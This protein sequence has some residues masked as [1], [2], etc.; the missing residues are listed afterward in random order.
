MADFR[1]APFRDLVTRLHREPLVQNAL[2]G[3]PQRH[4]RRSDPDEPDTG[5][6]FGDERVGAPCGPAAGP[7]TQLAQ[8]IL[9]SYVAGGRVIELKTAHDQGRGRVPNAAASFLEPDVWIDWALP[10]SLADAA[11]EY[12]AG[13]M[14]IEMFRR[15]HGL[16]GG[17]NEG[18]SGSWAFEV[19]VGYD[20]AGISRAGVRGF[21]DE[22]AQAGAVV[23]RLRSEIP[24]EFPEAREHAY[25]TR[26]A[27]A[28]SLS[29]CRD[30]S[31]DEIEK[32][33][34]LLIGQ[35]GLDLSLRLDAG[36]SGRKSSKLCFAANWDT[37]T[38]AS[39]RR[40]LKPACRCAR[41][42]RS[43]GGLEPAPCDAAGIFASNSAGRSKFCARAGS[44]PG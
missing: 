11:C 22:I 25:P 36:C 29:V 1:P 33:G 19:G 10:V 18:L 17:G 4:W 38:C 39:T 8:G 21:L 7:H 42:P 26:V 3:L 6:F 40:C 20:L 35:H 30:V 12:V 43:A 23:S 44:E 15:D 27:R 16:F 2:F 5:V 9:L 28:V 14:L 32:I 37:R 24:H 13:A 31:A 41:R 34:E